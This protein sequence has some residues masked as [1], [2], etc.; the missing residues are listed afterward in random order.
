MELINRR[1]QVID[2]AH[3]GSPSLC[4][5]VEDLL[6]EGTEAVLRLIR[7][8]AVSVRAI[9]Y[10]KRELSALR[11]IA[12]PG[13][14]RVLDF[15]V[16]QSIDGHNALSL[17]YYLTHE[18]IPPHRSILQE[19]TGRDIKSIV[20]AIVDLC[21]VLGYLHD[22]GYVYGC[23]DQNTVSVVD[24][25]AGPTVKLTRCAL[26]ADAEKG[27]FR[28]RDVSPQFMSPE[29]I[30]RDPASPASDLYSLGVLLLYLLTGEDPSAVSVSDALEQHRES[31]RLR[32]FAPLIDRL[33]A[34]PE[35][36]YT[37]TR[38]V[39]AHI[40]MVMGS[41]YPLFTRSSKDKIISNTKLVGRDAELHQLNEWKTQV[42]RRSRSPSLTLVD[43]SMG[44]GKTR[45]IREL[46]FHME[47]ER[48]RVFTVSFSEAHQIALEQVTQLV[49]S[50]VPFATNESLTK[51]GSELI[52]VVP[53]LL[54]GHNIQPTP[55]LSAER[56]MLRL[57]DRL[58][59]FILDTFD[60]QRVAIVLDNAQWADQHTLQLIEHILSTPK[61]V[62]LWLILAYRQ[63][64]VDGRPL[65]G[66]IERWHA[67]TGTTR[68]TLS[69]FEPEATSELVLQM[70]GS[71]PVLTQLSARIHRE[72]E[73]NPLFVKDIVN[74]LHSQGHL[75]IDDEGYWRTDF[76]VHGDT[77]KLPVPSNVYEAALNQVASLPDDARA[78]LETLSVFMSAA[79]LE[80]VQEVCG[81]SRDRLVQ[82]LNELMSLQLIDERDDDRGYAYD[83]RL[84]SIKRGLCDSMDEPRKQELHRRIAKAL[85]S[86]LNRDDT[87]MSHE[88]V[89]H[90]KEAGESSP[91]LE[92]ALSS[93]QS[94]LEIGID[95]SARLFLT[96]AYG[97]AK[98]LG[99]D[100]KA[101]RI[102]FL[103]SE[104]YE[105][106]GMYERAFDAYQETLELAAK[107]SNVK[108]QALAKQGIGLLHVR[109][110]NI[111]AASDSLYEALDLAQSIDFSEAVLRSTYSLCAM[112]L[113]QQ[114]YDE[115]VELASKCLDSYPNDEFLEI[116][117]LL[118]NLIGACYDAKAK[119]SEAL[120]RYQESIRLFN[121]SGRYWEA[122]RPVNNIGNVYSD[123]L[124]MPEKARAHYQKALDIVEKYGQPAI[125]ET[126]L[127]NIGE[128]Y[129][130]Q[131]QHSAALEYYHEAEKLSLESD[132][133][134]PLLVCRINMVLSYMVVGDYRRS[135]DYL[136][137]AQ[138]EIEKHGDDFAKYIP[139]F[140][141]YAATLF[142]VLGDF[143][144][145]SAYLSDNSQ[146]RTGA[147]PGHHLHLYEQALGLCIDYAKTGTLDLDRI[148]ALASHYRQTEYVKDCR[149]WFH[150]LA[151]LL[152]EAGELEKAAALVSESAQMAN[153]YDTQR[154]SAELLLL[155]G[156][157]SKG[158]T[159]IRLIC[160]SIER[161]KPI[162][163]PMLE[164]KAHQALGNT[165][166]SQG[167][168][169]RATAAYTSAADALYRLA[170]NVP[171]EYQ[172]AFI[173]SHNRQA[174][175]E[176]LLS[177][178]RSRLENERELILKEEHSDL[179]READPLAGFFGFMDAYNRLSDEAA[180]SLAIPSAG[181]SD[182]IV[183]LLD[184]ILDSPPSN[185]QYNVER[186]LSVLAEITCA[187]TACVFELDNGDAVP[188]YSV[189]TAP[190]VT[191]LSAVLD[192]ARS[193]SRGTLI[194]AELG[195]QDHPVDIALPKNAR[196]LI[197]IPL[198][199]GGIEDSS[200]KPDQRRSRSRLTRSILGYLYLSSSSVFGQFNERTLRVCQG[201]AAIV[202]ILIENR[203][204]RLVSSIDKVSGVYTRKHFEQAIA[205]ELHKAARDQYSLSL[206]MIDVDEFKNV[207]D[208]YGHQRGDEV[209]RDIGRILLENI[210]P[211]DICCRY[212]GEEFA[213]LL[214]D[215]S[216]D[217]AVTV[218]ERLRAAV[219][220]SK[221]MGSS[222]PLTISL[223]IASYPAHGEWQDELVTRADQ[224]LYQAK[225]LGRNNTVVWDHS[226]SGTARR[227]DRLA[228]IV[229][230]N[231]VQD[232]RNVLAMI[233]MIE[234]VHQPIGRE[235]KI[236][237]LLGRTISVL[238]AQLGALVVVD[239]N[240]PSTRMYTRKSQGEGWV[241]ESVC[242][243]QIIDDVLSSGE[244]IYCVDWDHVHGLDPVSGDPVWH[245]VIA[246]PVKRG[247]STLG[248]LCLSTS[249]SR[250]EYGSSE[251]NFAD[252]IGQIIALAF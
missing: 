225:Q 251:L 127:N 108:A 21:H 60:K 92:I 212:G 101:T 28:P 186:I 191:E 140:D 57:S 234:L 247:G 118:E 138:A 48:I 43:G 248:V 135:C 109:M 125:T 164:L 106:L 188:T 67:W 249:I 233:E 18:Y 174:V 142:Y 78:V 153:R 75:Y 76:D 99:D 160:R 52:K 238:D 202:R 218:A 250:H 242:S 15:G 12:H 175:R 89:F 183:D 8:E 200:F 87:D 54:S 110:N 59:N 208:T 207:N 224:A 111:E 141:K 157:L 189:G 229:T 29:Q 240:E 165:L 220:Y 190:S 62:A 201:L 239:D 102:L 58:S 166:Y 235:D 6:Q 84:R 117:G 4:Y 223:G 134:L 82:I 196:A 182:W 2:I 139:T 46:C 25:Q 39:I 17:Q 88:L 226:I 210:R 9:D 246:V 91:A 66:F 61:A 11:S 192:H 27:I 22:M 71:S 161:C 1:Y 95:S 3:D 214:P 230:G 152:I 159:A 81:V 194:R 148:D 193:D 34:P 177:I 24:G 146:T 169:L 170:R 215:T 129:R 213:I 100:S 85:E 128:T 26:D 187:D 93:A 86:S 97:I 245:S 132:R 232:Q 167:D 211:Q 36:R 72:T 16:V 131:D 80:A 252:T 136:R 14:V 151:D 112:M 44:V 123:H 10:L 150:V 122:A 38:Q 137:L 70:L 163:D 178:R 79:P 222:M 221:L 120:S 219:E 217:D 243:P 241:S 31:R 184:E 236:Y 179:N 40:N 119:S 216:E 162:L 7:P 204:L 180:C 33:I 158:D 35:K 94:L 77:Y 130:A 63:E 42:L 45:L 55:A 51:Y 90:L 133:R 113:S 156:Q 56:E 173:L 149:D 13:L 209:L 73:G 195:D 176:R 23:L 124:Q 47:L 98:D 41:D 96:E 144:R 199:E 155:Q 50:L 172:R 114:R 231:T 69:P 65:Q 227:M 115:I 104:T 147:E 32:S 168:T 206:I 68:L 83:I 19:Y 116:R 244:S 181:T 185:H 105:R 205:N 20:T 49:R 64:E 74:A 30:R 5:L 145:A 126:L 197:C 121:L 107:T 198:F 237:R 103:L 171:K 37:D 228:G 143:D 203:H 53:D 154:L